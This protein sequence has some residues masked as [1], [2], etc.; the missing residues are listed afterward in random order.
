MIRRPPRSTLFPY[1]TLFRSATMRRFGATLSPPA[2]LQSGKRSLIEATANLLDVARHRPIIVQ[3]YVHAIV[4]DVARQLHAPAGLSESALV[5]WLRRSGPVREAQ[6]DC[7][8]VLSKADELAAG[9]R[10]RRVP[11]G[12]PSGA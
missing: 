8:A 12:A 5:E 10:G 1:T 3:R 2:V 11:L 9:G 6:I 7:G 4:Q